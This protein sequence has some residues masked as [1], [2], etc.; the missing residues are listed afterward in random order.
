MNKPVHS[1]D[2]IIESIMDLIGLWYVVQVYFFGLNGKLL[3]RMNCRLE[4][5]S[6]LLCE[7][8]DHRVLSFLDTKT[9]TNCRLKQEEPSK[10]ILQIYREIR[11]IQ[12]FCFGCSFCHSASPFT[13]D[14]IWQEE[15]DETFGKK[16]C[17]SHQNHNKS[18]NSTE[19]H[20]TRLGDLL[21]AYNVSK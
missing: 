5:T 4:Q 12:I 13:H 21:P 16:N 11:P 18:L 1:C 17:T 3:N 19:K 15:Q 14:Y 6:R 7:T 2:I 20:N 10:K 8:H 9:Q